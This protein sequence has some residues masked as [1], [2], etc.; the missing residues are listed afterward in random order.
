MAAAAFLA[1]DGRAR[2]GFGHREQIFQIQRRVPAGIVFAMAVNGDLSGAFLR[3]CRCRRAPGPFRPR[4]ARCRRGFASFPANHA[5]PDT[6]PS[7]LPP[8]RRPAIKRFERLAR[9]RF[10]LRV[11]DLAGAVFLREFRGEFAGAFAEHDQIG[12]RIAAQPVRAVQTGGALRPPRTVP[13]R[14]TSACRRSRGRR[15]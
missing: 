14:W 8:A 10:D 12:K 5:A 2:D 1:F 15:P 4:A 11:V 7:A 13:A 3:V 9:G 6:V